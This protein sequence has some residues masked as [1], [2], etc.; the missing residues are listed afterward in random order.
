MQTSGRTF[1]SAAPAPQAGRNRLEVLPSA[2]SGGRVVFRYEVSGEWAECFRAGKAFFVE[3]P[4]DAERVPE[5]VRIVPF[6]SQVLPVAWICDAEVRVPACDRD[7][8]ECLEAVE[9]G[10][11]AMHPRIAF[12][13]KL[14]A[15]RLER[16]A[17]AGK[18]SARPIAC[19]SG[20][21][22]AHAT[23][24]RHL[25]EKPLLSAV[26][27]SDVPWEDEEGWKPVEALV[28]G[29]A[30]KL[31]LELLPIRS[32]FRDLLD[33]RQLDRR[34][35]AS[36]DIWWHGFQ[37]GLGI[38]GHLAP[39]A[40]K[41]GAGT[42]YI[43]SSFT[44][45][46][47]YTCASDPSIDDHVRFCGAAVVHDG[48]E[49]S[50]QDKVRLIAEWSS[51]T[52]TKLPL[53][54]CWKKKGGD[55]CC[56]CE[57][58]WRT[59]LAL[60]AEGAD[61][62]DF[63]FGGFDGFGSLPV[64]MERDAKGFRT[65]MAAHYGPIR[66]RLADRMPKKALP[67]ELAW[68]VRGGGPAVARARLE[69]ARARNA[70]SKTETRTETVARLRETAA[71][72][73]GPLV[74]RDYRYLVMPDHGN[75]GDFFIYLGERAFLAT[76]GFKCLEE[77]T[78][79]SFSA[80][81]PGIGGDDLLVLRGGG[82][83]GDIWPHWSFCADVLARRKDNPVLILPQ[84]VHFTRNENLEE[85]RRAVA[86]HGKTTLCVRDRASFRFASEN[87]DCRVVLAPDSA[88]FWNPGGDRQ[89][90]KG[91][92]LVERHDREASWFSG[93]SEAPERAAA[94]VAD[95]PSLDFPDCEW[96]ILCRLQKRVPDEPGEYD[97]FVR[98]V[99]CPHV[100]NRAVR[101]F[102]PFKTVWSTRLHGAILAILMDKETVVID[103]RFGKSKAFYDTWLSGCEGVDL[104]E[105]QGE[106]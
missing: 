34:V 7:F 55:N 71:K 77:T 65:R 45:A 61:P 81:N 70:D 104:L 15:D 59:M 17:P 5:G 12:G 42:V 3:Y 67:A 69:E 52:G 53:H 26:W 58:C 97:R 31:G 100:A 72:T 43:A 19:F 54:V 51:R 10:Y 47:S 92:L 86:A 84:S 22:D 8:F 50:R 29:N 96:R 20:G 16:G 78:M 95:W 11:R 6:L 30:E 60:W 9:G 36:G 73:L 44:A 41:T 74:D 75:A 33:L 39:V 83:F 23:V 32:S 64:D 99:W 82:W 88:F 24:L 57:K 79:R 21:V 66:K 89:P 87:F 38:L 105:P 14:V 90:E 18:P 56:H 63:G 98:N 46:D 40:W 1:L 91:D 4:F 2:V 28:R 35:E 62:R 37:H 106:R 48:Y 80:G 25:S 13:G 85:M 101:L 102:R 27:G 76:T 49:C 93:L 103:N 94:T 68:L